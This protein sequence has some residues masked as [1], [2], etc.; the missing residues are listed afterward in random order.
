MSSPKSLEKVRE[1]SKEFAEYGVNL[2]TLFLM[3]PKIIK[4]LDSIREES[5]E[6]AAKV[7]ENMK[8]KL[9]VLGLEVSDVFVTINNE[10][11]KE[12]RSLKGKEDGKNL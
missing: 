11:A 8:A 12:I 6:E 3:E 7:A 4:A 10:T 9:K 1:I 5:L 2:I